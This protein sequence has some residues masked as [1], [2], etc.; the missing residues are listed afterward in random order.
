MLFRSLGQTIS[1]GLNLRL[2]SNLGGFILSASITTEGDNPGPDGLCGTADDIPSGTFGTISISQSVI[3]VLNT[4]YGSATVANLYD[5]ANRA[6]ACQPIGGLSLSDVNNAVDA[7]NQGFDHCRIPVSSSAKAEADQEAPVLPEPMDNLI[8][9]YPNPLTNA[10]TFEF[11]IPENGKV[12]LEVFNSAG[13]KVAGLFDKT[14][15]AGVTYKVNFNA[16]TLARG[17]YLY[18]FQ[19]SGRYYSHKLVIID[20]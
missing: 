7:V 12:I 20:K 3:D 5:L 15:E 1:L 19:A 10:T 4:E 6:L 11:S 9:A 14:V 16:S 2:S 18:R 17:L 13:A 8:K